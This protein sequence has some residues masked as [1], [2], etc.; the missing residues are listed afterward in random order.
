M[1]EPLAGGN[2]LAHAVDRGEIDGV[3]AFDN[4]NDER[5]GWTVVTRFVELAVEPE[6]FDAAEPPL[7]TSG[8][9]KAFEARFDPGIASHG[10]S[11]AQFSVQVDHLVL[12]AT[13]DTIAPERGP[14][15]V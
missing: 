8:E 1:A 13:R 2:M 3:A 9:A 12:P 5:H 11:A 10:H 14:R 4:G 7:Y 15:H 6:K